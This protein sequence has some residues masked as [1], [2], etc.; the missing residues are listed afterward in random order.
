MIRYMSEKEMHCCPDTGIYTA[1]GIKAYQVSDNE[2]TIIAY[3]PDV[4]L[5]KKE[6]D[7]FAFLCTQLNLAPCHL[8]D[9]VDDYL[10]TI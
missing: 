10:S 3:I 6:A 4:F 1:W 7:D 2:Q 9:V 8:D 5:C